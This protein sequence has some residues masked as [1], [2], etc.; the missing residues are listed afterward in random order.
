MLATA[1]SPSL[2]SLLILSLLPL[3]AVALL[4]HSVRLVLLPS[5]SGARVVWRVDLHRRCVAYV[6]RGLVTLVDGVQDDSVTTGKED[7][8]RSTHHLPPG[9]LSSGRGRKLSLWPHSE[10]EDRPSGVLDVKPSSAR[11][12]VSAAAAALSVTGRSSTFNR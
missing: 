5:S 12:V 6:V 4:F 3:G 10:R 11:L 1:A 7:A 8:C 9:S 2:L